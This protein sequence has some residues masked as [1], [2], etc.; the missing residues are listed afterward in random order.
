MAVRQEL[1][2]RKQLSLAERSEQASVH[3]IKNQIA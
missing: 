1:M 3:D 2:I